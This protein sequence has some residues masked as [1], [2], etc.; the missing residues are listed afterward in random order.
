MQ[1][2]ATPVQV[3]GIGGTLLVDPTTSVLLAPLTL[4][5]PAGTATTAFAIPV[6][7]GLLGFDLYTQGLVWGATLAFTP[8]VHERV[9]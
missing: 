3:P 9:L 1:R 8:A 7:P 5:A 6:Q 2:L 4:P